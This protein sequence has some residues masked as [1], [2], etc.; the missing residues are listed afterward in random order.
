MR[1]VG[2]VHDVSGRTVLDTSLACGK[3]IA[4]RA[5]FTA[6]S[7]LPLTRP[8][9]FGWWLGGQLTVSLSDASPTAPGT[10]GGL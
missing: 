8:N 9:R 7:R 3:Q 5:R 6:L 1:V 4:P 2:P 10:A